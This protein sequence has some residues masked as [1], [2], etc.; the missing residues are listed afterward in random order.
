MIVA[1]AAG[2][3]CPMA[4]STLDIGAIG[5]ALGLELVVQVIVA[6]GQA[7]PDWSR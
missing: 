5:L 7:Q 2:L 4:V 1:V 6:I 3:G